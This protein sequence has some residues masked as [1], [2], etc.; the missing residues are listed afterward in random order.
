M[1]EILYCSIPVLAWILGYAFCAIIQNVKWTSRAGSAR[2]V[3][4][5]KRHFIVD[6]INISGAIEQNIH[7]AKEWVHQPMMAPLPLQFFPQVM[8]PLT[9]LV[10]RYQVE[11]GRRLMAYTTFDRRS[12]PQAYARALEALG[13]HMAKQIMEHEASKRTGA[14]AIG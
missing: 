13:M 11:P 8:G 4:I 12:T 5:G 2:F 14:G 9:R 1:K 10:V 7:H 6:E 3:K